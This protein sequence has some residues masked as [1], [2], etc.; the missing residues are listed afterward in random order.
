MASLKASHDNEVFVAFTVPWP[1]RNELESGFDAREG[2]T[3]DA[4]APPGL[5]EL[6]GVLRTVPVL[7]VTLGDHIVEAWQAPYDVPEPLDGE[8]IPDVAVGPDLEGLRLGL[9]WRSVEGRWRQEGLTAEV[10]KGRLRN[11]WGTDAEVWIS[12]GALGSVTLAFHAARK[13][14]SAT[15]DNRTLRWASIAMVERGRSSA[16][17]ML[18]RSTALDPRVLR[19]MQVCGGSRWSPLVIRT[20][21]KSKD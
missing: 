16:A 6:Q 7:R 8:E 21:R 11:F 20:A 19:A 12:G 5:D 18:R 1:G 9:R 4:E 13:A 3:F 15:S 2:L 10:V 14:R 17:W